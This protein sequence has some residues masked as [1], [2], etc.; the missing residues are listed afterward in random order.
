MLYI[1]STV[2][3]NETHFLF[4]ATRQESL[5]KEKRDSDVAAVLSSQI[6]NYISRCLAVTFSKMALHSPHI[7]KGLM[8][9]PASHLEGARGAI[10]I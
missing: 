5:S 1:S 2:N 7:Q 4:L 6:A 9:P 8:V 3:Y 10:F